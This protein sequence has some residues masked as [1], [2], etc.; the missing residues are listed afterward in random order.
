MVHITFLAATN[1]LLKNCIQMEF[2]EIES[3]K[4]NDF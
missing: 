1:I 2:L 4:K 3:Y